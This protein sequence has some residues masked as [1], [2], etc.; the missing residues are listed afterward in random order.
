MVVEFCFP[1]VFCLIRG[2][3][4]EIGSEEIVFLLK[5]GAMIWISDQI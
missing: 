1:E 2:G 3:I 4:V 5:L